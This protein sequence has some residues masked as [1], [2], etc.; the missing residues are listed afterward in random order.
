MVE[1]SRKTEESEQK[2][3]MEHLDR[4]CPK[5]LERERCPKTP[6]GCP[7]VQ[8]GGTPGLPTGFKVRRVVRVEDSG[9]WSDYIAKREQIAVTREA[10]M[11]LP[12]L[13]PAIISDEAEVYLWHG[14]NVRAALSIAQNDF[15]ID[16]AGS[17]TGTMYGRGAYLAEHCTKADEYA[18]D[19]PGGYYEG[20]YALLLC[21]VCLGKFYYTKVRDPECGQKVK[22]GEF[23][24]DRLAAADT[25]REFVVYDAD[26]IYP[27]P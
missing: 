1:K 24:R 4:R 16:L 5:R 19:E 14:T 11:P 6:G 21:R 13:D 18:V 10:E 22:S 3:S 15:S 8:P 9:M 12:Q 7:C 27:A 25:F 20:V 26:Q 17:S 23:D 2:N